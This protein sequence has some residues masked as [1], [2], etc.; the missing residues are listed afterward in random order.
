[1]TLKNAYAVI[2]AGGF[3][4]RFWPASRR[5]RPKQ[6]LPLLGRESLLQLT[7]RRLARL[8]PPSRI[9]VVGNAEHRALL[10]RQLP[11]VPPGRLLLEP[12]GRNTTAAAA[13]AAE[14]IRTALPLGADAA[15]GIFPAD[16][17]IRH[18][19]RFLHLARAALAAAAE[20]NAVIVL[21]VPPLRSETGYGY[22]ERGRSLRRQN[23]ER[24]FAV[25]RFTEKPGARRA[26]RYLRS[27]RYFWNSGMFFWRLST[28]DRLL[29]RHLP[30]TRR[31]F[32]NLA[33]A[34]GT[35]GYSLCLRRSYRS[36]E[37]ISIDYALAEPA[38]AR[39]Q[40]HMLEAAIG[41]SDLG[42]WTA[43]YDW[44]AV[45]RGENIVAGPHL[46][47]DARGN[48]LSAPRKFLAAIGVRDLIVVD[49]PDA[50]LLCAREHAQ[51]VGKVVDYL[52]KSRRSRLL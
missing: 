26:D 37:N 6:F 13:L 11:R 10:A 42:S 34:I 8:F 15:L 4:T 33:A 49:T 12:L 23:G 24:V 45:R 14:H 41:W 17:G 18:E 32:E 28:F 31:A 36:L 1:V 20:E 27:G 9:Y 48:W 40:V 30:W 39:G 7:Y 47:L 46:L 21:G 35:R 52:K 16:H 51:E 25:R 43:V 29:A 5:S 50:V 2:L 19:A 44:C 3:G 38:A 22:I